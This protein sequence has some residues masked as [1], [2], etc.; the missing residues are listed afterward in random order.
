MNSE[1]D[2]PPTFSVIYCI[3]FSIKN[4]DDVSLFGRVDN[5]CP[6]IFKIHGNFKDTFLNEI[7]YKSYLIKTH[8]LYKRDFF[9]Y[10]Y[11]VFMIINTKNYVYDEKLFVDISLISFKLNN[12]FL[13]TKEL[14]KEYIPKNQIKSINSLKSYQRLVITGIT[15]FM[16]TK[17]LIKFYNDDYYYISN[18]WFE[19]AYLNIKRLIQNRLIICTLN[20]IKRVKFK[21][22]LNKW[23]KRVTLEIF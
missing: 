9:L 20:N 14:Q 17:F 8:F 2:L 11:D 7:F 5:C 22:F 4:K 15:P 1:S 12:Y 19:I 6:I 10:K 16:K 18:Y 23:Q 21:K 13:K 3:G